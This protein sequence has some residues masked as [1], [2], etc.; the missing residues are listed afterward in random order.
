MSELHWPWMESAVLIPLVGA[1]AVLWCRDP[2]HGR[3]WTSLISGITLLV[4]TG[5]WIDYAAQDA[6]QVHDLW[7]LTG[8]VLGER[9]F[10]LDDLSAPLLPMSALLYFLTAFATLRTKIRRFS[11]SGML[12][13]ESILL[14]LLSCQEAW[15][16]VAL[17]SLSVLPPL[18]EL[19]SRHRG[20]RVYSLHMTLFVMSLVGGWLWMRIGPVDKPPQ[21]AVLLLTASVLLR[22][23]IAPFHC[24]MTDLFENATLGTALLFMA[25]MPGAYAAIRLVFPVASD[26]VLHML[27][28]A[29]LATSVYAAGMALVQQ[30][31][32]RFFCYLFLSQSSLVLLGLQIATDISVTGALCVWLSVG[33]SLTGFGLTLR[34]LESRLGRLSLKEHRGL[35]EHTPMLAA[36]FLVTGLASVGFPGTLGFVAVELLVDGAVQMHPFIGAA[37]VLV[38]ALNG[39]AVLQVYFRL[40]AGRRHVTSIPLHCRFSERFAVLVLTALIVGGGL[41]PQSGVASRYHVAWQINHARPLTTHDDPIEDWTRPG[42]VRDS[43]DARSPYMGTPLEHSRP[44]EGVEVDPVGSTPLNSR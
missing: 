41:F 44:R 33:L 5:S 30:E 35:A 39:I 28:M 16:L 13:S 19:R 43:S 23:G 36:F 31:A 25:P 15:G 26:S 9:F 24:W 3:W 27:A 29:P 14:T 1:I 37:V 8:G 17:L 6:E 38:A 40:F 42:G 34:S 7:D 20:I 21:G 2:I 22:S 32:R 12:L 18:W 4:A 10:E 11:Y